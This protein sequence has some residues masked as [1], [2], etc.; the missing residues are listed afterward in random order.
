MEKPQL[1]V[2]SMGMTK[3]ATILPAQVCDIRQG[4]DEEETP[5]FGLDFLLY[6]NIKIAYT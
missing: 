3:P 5:R 6:S 1:L 4:R 2:I